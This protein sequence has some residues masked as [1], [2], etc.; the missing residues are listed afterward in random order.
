MNKKLYIVLILDF[1]CLFL[2]YNVTEFILT[3]DIPAIQF[4]QISISILFLFL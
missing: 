4:K 3:S 1:I 2:S